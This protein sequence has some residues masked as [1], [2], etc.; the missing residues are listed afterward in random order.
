MLSSAALQAGNDPDI[1]ASR[2]MSV[3][4]KVN[5]AEILARRF[6]ADLKSNISAS[7]FLS[8]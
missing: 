5:P 7:F 2:K 1:D 3:A 8:F 6:C 4:G